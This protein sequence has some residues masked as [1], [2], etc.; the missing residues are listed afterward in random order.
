[1]YAHSLHPT[2]NKPKANK[3]APRQLSHPLASSAIRHLRFPAPTQ[4]P[5]ERTP[6]PTNQ[7]PTKP[8]TPPVPAL[9]LHH[10]RDVQ[11]LGLHLGACSGAGTRG[12]TLIHVGKFL[13]ALRLVGDS[14]RDSDHSLHRNALSVEDGWRRHH[15][16]V[17][18]ADRSGVSVG[19]RMHAGKQA[20]RLGVDACPRLHFPTPPLLHPS[21]CLSRHRAAQSCVASLPS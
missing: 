14:G 2:Q 8:T 9:H 7:P 19:T 4:S 10:V 3:H 1:V 18:A 20:C 15:H 12:H 16:F 13:S 17:S 21:L 11:L 6:Q 5:N